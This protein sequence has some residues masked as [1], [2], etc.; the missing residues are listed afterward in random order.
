MEVN[1]VSKKKA[2]V[3]SFYVVIVGETIIRIQ[4]CQPNLAYI[5]PG[6]LLSLASTQ[7][8]FQKV[9]SFMIISTQMHR[10]VIIDGMSSLKQYRHKEWKADRKAN[11]LN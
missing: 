9:Q 3:P 8:Y 6:K 1:T 10:S 5:Q 2:A 4:L 11:E 7:L